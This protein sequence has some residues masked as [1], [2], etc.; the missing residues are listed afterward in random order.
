M[1]WMPNRRSHVKQCELYALNTFILVHPTT[2]FFHIINIFFYSINEF[3]WIRFVFVRK[4]LRTL[5][6]SFSA[7]FCA[8]T[9]LISINSNQCWNHLNEF[10]ATK[11][12]LELQIIIKK[13]R[14]KA[15]KHR[16]QIAIICK[17]I[18]FIHAPRQKYLA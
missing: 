4:F 11:Y 13:K 15:D 3:K 5:V 18:Q 1:H 17:F 12:I 6:S 10:R 8:L 2:D 14:S 16:K 9:R 7:S